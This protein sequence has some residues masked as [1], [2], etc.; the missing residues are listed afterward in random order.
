MGKPR[1]PKELKVLEGSY[2]ADRDRGDAPILPA[3]ATSTPAPKSLGEHGA[4]VWRELFPDLVGAGI[5]TA[6]DVPAF[7]TY[8]RTHD[9][10][11]DCD[12]TLAKEGHYILAGNGALKAHPALSVR[13]RWLSLQRD[14][15]K[16]FGLTSASRQAIHVP[17]DDDMEGGI[18]TRRRGD[19]L[20]RFLAGNE[21]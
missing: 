3:A 5:V 13:F 20:D 17:T 16:Q 8:C 7:E 6:C 21:G 12:E 2:R 11:A 18:L 1:K 19:E 10:I 15:A 14:Y 9:E 4:K